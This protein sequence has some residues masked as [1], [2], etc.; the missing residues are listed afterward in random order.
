MY[1]FF[2]QSLKPFAL[3]ELI[4]Q[5]AKLTGI[6]KLC[7]CIFALAV[8]HSSHPELRQCARESLRNLLPDLLDSYL[9]QNAAASG[10]HEISFDLL[11]YL[12]CCL[13]EYVS[14]KLE[15]QFLNKLREEFPREAVPL[16]LAPILYRSATTSPATTTTASTPTSASSSKSN[17]T[18]AE[19]ET[20]ITTNTNS[21]SNSSWSSSDADIL[22]EVGIEDIYDH[23][24]EIIFT[25]Q[26]TTYMPNSSAYQSHY[27]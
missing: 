13:H 19:E 1:V 4:G 12:L 20:T 5:V 26:V 17:E 18:D 15:A 22:N 25:T 2:D 16:V 27:L 14:P 3:A 21:T 8:T 10:L 7:E 6:N 24:C 23:L 11:Q 9:G